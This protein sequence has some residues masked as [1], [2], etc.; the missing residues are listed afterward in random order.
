MTTTIT[1]DETTWAAA[2][3]HLRGSVEQVGFFLADYDEPARRFAI[4][5]FRAL[6]ETAF[7]IQSAVHVSLKD[8]VR[9]QVV[10]WA[11]RE[12]ACLIEAHSHVW[13]PAA[14]SDVYGFASWVPHVRWRLR[15]RPYAAVVMAEGTFDTLAWIEASPMPEQVTTIEI[16]D[17]ELPATGMTLPRWAELERWSLRD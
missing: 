13:G 5:G 11:T 10:G 1:V 7:E 12:S 17:H 2:C 4:R 14:V 16:G 6:P 9:P 3:D 15:R 8:E